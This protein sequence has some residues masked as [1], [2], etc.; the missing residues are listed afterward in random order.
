M[1]HSSDAYF[2]IRQHLRW[3]WTVILITVFSF[4]IFHKSLLILFTMGDSAMCSLYSLAHDYQVS[5]G[6]LTVCEVVKLE[7]G[8]E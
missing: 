1:W 6:V 4:F 5:L 2:Y 3:N 7:L 8:V